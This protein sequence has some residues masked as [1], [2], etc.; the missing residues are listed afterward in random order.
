[1]E[2]EN[3]VIERPFLVF[4]WLEDFS[5]PGSRSVIL[6]GQCNFSEPE[7]FVLSQCCTNSRLW[8]QKESWTVSVRNLLIIR[9][10]LPEKVD[11]GGQHVLQ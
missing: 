3:Q 7:A 1:M 2:R 11:F 6:L 4:V 9:N 10:Y 8:C 5:P